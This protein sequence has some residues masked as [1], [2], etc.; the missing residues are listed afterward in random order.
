MKD[1]L[2]ILSLPRTESESSCL[3]IRSLRTIFG[4][5]LGPIG[6]RVTA[7]DPRHD[8]NMLPNLINFKVI[9]FIYLA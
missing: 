4:G 8:F 5:I 2:K 9:N 7:V 1:I 3:R 6:F